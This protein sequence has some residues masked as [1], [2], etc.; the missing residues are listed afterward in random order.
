MDLSEIILNLSILAYLTL[1]F[2]NH[3]IIESILEDSPCII[4]YT[5][6]S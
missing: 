3:S 1:G 5:E 6:P 2:F 4:P